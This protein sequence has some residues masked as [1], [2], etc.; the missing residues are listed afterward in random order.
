MMSPLHNRQLA[1]KYTI[2]AADLSIAS[3]AYSEGYMYLQYSQ[4]FIKYD[5]ELKLLLRVI[6]TAL[7]EMRPQNY[8]KNVLPPSKT[9]NIASSIGSFRTNDK[10]ILN[11]SVE[12]YTAEDYRNYQRLLDDLSLAL[13]ANELNGVKLDNDNA[14]SEF[15][16][17]EMVNVEK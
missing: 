2:K 15:E 17:C 12:L 9:K 8:P 6:E 16:E 10:S 13:D 4:D 5:T 7:Y 1:F 14:E 11:R 3:G